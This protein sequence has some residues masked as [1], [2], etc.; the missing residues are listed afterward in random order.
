MIVLK[1][2]QCSSAGDI[3]LSKQCV[4]QRSHGIVQYVQSSIY[5]SEDGGATKVATRPE[6]GSIKGSEEP[7]RDE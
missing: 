3:I 2:T 1:S 5:M 4:F 6:G 7:R